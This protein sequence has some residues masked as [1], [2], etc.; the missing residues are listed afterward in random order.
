MLLSTPTNSVTSLRYFNK[1]TMTWI[2]LLAF[3][4]QFITAFIFLLFISKV[5]Y[6]R[7][8]FLSF[9]LSTECFLHWCTHYIEQQ[10]T[11]NDKVMKCI[12]LDPRP[13]TRHSSLVC[14]TN[15]MYLFYGDKINKFTTGCCRRDYTAWPSGRI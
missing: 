2:F 5:L 7:F 8:F 10:Y 3:F 15:N 11:N 1:P 12:A 13:Q 6:R 4:A 9:L 14:Y